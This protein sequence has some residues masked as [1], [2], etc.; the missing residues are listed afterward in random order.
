MKTKTKRYL[1]IAVVFVTVIVTI[2][3]LLPREKA[4][5]IEFTQGKPWRYEQLTA[6]FD[7]AVAKSEAALERERAEVVAAQRP[8][9]N[10]EVKGFGIVNKAEIDVFL[11]HSCFFHDPSDVGNLIS[12]SCAFSCA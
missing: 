12:G 6:P 2:C 7:F 5:N 9:Y 4:V 1:F 10:R 11:I 8:Y 3:L